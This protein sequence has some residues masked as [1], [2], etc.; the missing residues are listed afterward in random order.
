[1][2][3]TPTV[4]VVLVSMA[5]KSP[6]IASKDVQNANAAV[7]TLQPALRASLEAP[8]TLF[9]VHATR[10]ISAME[11]RVAHAKLAAL[12]EGRLHP[13]LRAVPPTL[14][15]VLATLDTTA[16]ELRAPPAKHAVP[17]HLRPP[18]A[19]REARPTG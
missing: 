1:M 6:S 17:M 13:V 19:L 12:K 2:E 3:P 5:G 9:N 15:H 14:C 11:L 10:A 4:N 18:R 7:R 8:S 16:T